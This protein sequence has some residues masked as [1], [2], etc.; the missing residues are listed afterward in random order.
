MQEKS[1][2][3][4]NQVSFKGR[5]GYFFAMQATGFQIAI[6]TFLIFYGTQSLALSI[7]AISLMMTVVKVLDGFTDIVAGF[8]IDKTKD[9]TGKARP[10]F[11]WMALPYA[12]CFALEFCVPTSWSPSAKLI[13]LAVTYALTISVFGTMLG[14]AGAALLPLLTSS[15]KERGIL[16]VVCGGA[17]VVVVGFLMAMIFPLVNAFGYQKVFITFAVVSFIFCVLCYLLVTEQDIESYVMG[18]GKTPTMGEL[19][20]ALINNKYALLV[21]VYILL[22][23]C[24]GSIL[25]GAGTY[26]AT[27]VLKDASMFTKFMLAGTIGTLVGIFIGMPLVKRFG[28]RTLFAV[29]AAMAVLGFGAI[30]LTDSKNNTVIIV[31]FFFTLMGGQLFTLTQISAMA[32]AAVDYGEWKNGVRSEGVTVCLR[33]FGSKV[34]GALGTAMMGISLAAS[35]FVA[36]GKAQTPEAINGIKL[37]MTALSP[38]VY[39]ILLI[40]FLLTYKLEKQLPAIQKEL[41]ARREGKAIS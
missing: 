38:L 34:G 37:T 27:Y 41:K 5:L 7:V 21:L 3:N 40:I 32:A 26:Y 20:K 17:G 8:I 1:L 36:G 19:L 9:K 12:L 2:N 6:P 35:G 16:A 4:D 28:T 24:A 31:A 30:L 15:S 22:N 25:Q 33:S 23:Q 13:M 29:G 18:K 14:V 11:L 10:W 39:L